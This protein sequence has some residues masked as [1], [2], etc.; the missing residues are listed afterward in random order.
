MISKLRRLEVA[1]TAEDAIKGAATL[2]IDPIAITKTRDILVQP[3][4]SKNAGISGFLM[5]Q[6]D[7]FGIGYSTKLTNQGFINF[8]VAHELG[9]YFL[10]GHHE[11]LFAT[12]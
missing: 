1:K 9:H 11:K 7:S 8:T 12:G 2:P 4:E 6:G 5:K 10:P 3:M